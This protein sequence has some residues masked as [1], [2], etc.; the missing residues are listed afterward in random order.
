V[1]LARSSTLPAVSTGAFS[2][3]PDLARQ[4]LATAYYSGQ[5]RL[6]QERVRLYQT[7]MTK[8]LWR[9]SE[10]RFA[11]TPDGTLYL[12]N[13]YTRLQAIVAAGVEAPFAV[14]VLDVP[15]LREVAAEYATL[16]AH[17]V[18]Q[19]KDLLRG[20][21]LENELG[22][23]LGDQE[24]VARTAGIVASGFGRSGSLRFARTIQF[25]LSY[26]LEW[27]PHARTL[28]TAI[29]TGHSPDPVTVR[30]A[31]APIFAVALVTA[32]FQP[33]QAQTFWGAVAAND[34]LRRGQPDWV[35]RDFL[36]RLS[37]STVREYP[38]MER[39]VAACWNAH[40][41]G[42]A[43]AFVSA[44]QNDDGE[45]APITLKGTPYDGR[46]TIQLY[47]GGSFIPGTEPESMRPERI[48]ARAARGEYPYTAAEDREQAVAH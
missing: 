4:W 42:R 16:D 28:L 24:K 40:V 41:E 44:R 31:N 48:W 25:R 14:V 26:L 8:G 5:R 47:G 9:L 39:R 34:G 6:S 12:L 19:T 21:D 36:A 23:N 43:M 7:E 3:G 46:Q 33:E 30:I 18:R 22:F 35:L 10:L 15:S 1:Q 13:G 32:R 29:R 38:G 37:T 27:A 20:Y 11:R 17:R 2:V 45:W